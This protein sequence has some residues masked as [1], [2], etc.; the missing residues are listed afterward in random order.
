[1][2]DEGLLRANNRNSFYLHVGAHVQLRYAH[3]GTCRG[4]FLEYFSSNLVQYRPLGHTVGKVNGRVHNIF[5]SGTMR[6]QS[7]FDALK[8]DSDLTF[9]CVSEPT[10]RRVNTNEPF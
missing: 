6:L 4:G 2:K 3:A 5:Q 10:G 9:D 8:Y 7:S 1:M